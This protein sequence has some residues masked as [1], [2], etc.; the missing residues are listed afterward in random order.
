MFVDSVI[1]IRNKE[2]HE[3][4]IIN[5]NDTLNG[6]VLKYII[7]FGIESNYRIKFPLIN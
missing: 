2:A 5:I 7:V 4:L 6:R 1:E 3:K